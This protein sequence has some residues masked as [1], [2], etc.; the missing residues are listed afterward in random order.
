MF[1]PPT[2]ASNADHDRVRLADWIELNLLADEEEFMSMDSVTAE[3]AGGPPDIGDDSEVRSPRED[4][5]DPDGATLPG[6]WN[7][8]EDGTAGAFRELSWRARWLR[9]QYPLHVADDM[10]EFSRTSETQDVYRFLV[11][12]RA[13]QLYE[14]AL[15][16]D[17]CTSG[18]LFEEVVKYALGSYIGAPPQNQVRFGVAGG[19]RGDGLPA[20][21]EQAVQDLSARLH[22][23]MGRVPER[24]T[25]DFRADAIA[26]KPFGDDISG[27]LAIIG[28]ATISEGHWERKEPADRWTERQRDNRDT[29]RLIEWFA[30][31]VTA[32]A[33]PETLSLTP[34]SVRRGLA[35]RSIPFDRLR[36]LT[37]LRDSQLPAVLT[38]R[39]KQWGN[40]VIGE[41]PR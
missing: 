31:P 13:R 33:F 36:L 10:A 32:V 2:R 20:P 38:E 25:G 18:L 40:A 41:I 14:N 19:S 9:A 8:L 37:Q 11:L 27:Q 24:A 35:L 28:Q 22:E 16:D 29:P 34:S 12:L 3:L 39:M 26:W 30:R 5:H 21:V 15:G 4:P 6:H 17:G 1:A 23:D 7:T